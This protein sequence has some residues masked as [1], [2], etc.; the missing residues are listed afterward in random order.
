MNK[1]I[2]YISAALLLGIISIT[3]I[4]SFIR[5]RERYLRE[6]MAQRGAQ[7]IVVA[8]QD[9]PRDQAIQ[10]PFITTKKILPNDMQS[11]ALSNPGTVIGKIARTGIYEGQQI[12]SSMIKFPEELKQLSKQ[13]PAGKRAVTIPVD[14][15]SSIDGNITPN[16]HIDIVSV[17][18]FNQESLIAPLFE[19][20]LVLDTGGE[21]RTQGQM[22]STL[23][24][25]LT[26]E[27]AALLT[28]VLEQGQIKI[29]LRSP[30]DTKKSLNKQPVTMQTLK[31]YWGMIEPPQPP[32]P[33]PE[34][35]DVYK[36]TEKQAVEI[37]KR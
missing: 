23:T 36:G 31:R 19:D 16:D 14:R 33:P 10:P 37:E 22:I 17:L 29:F 1:K 32:P 12:T 25:A 27:Q 34:T 26:P 28:Y 24:I 2:I 20:V 3:M 30:L 5:E 7:D 6:L 11:G 15:V 21:S 18:A 9:I 4:I 8:A 13:V 35:V